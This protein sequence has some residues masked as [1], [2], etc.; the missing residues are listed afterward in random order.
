MKRDIL[1]L[2]RLLHTCVKTLE[3]P[4]DRIGNLLDDR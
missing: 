2:L 3:G 1:L 4:F